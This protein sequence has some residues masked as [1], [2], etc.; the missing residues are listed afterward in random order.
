MPDS[1][2]SAI[3]GAIGIDSS[4]SAAGVDSG[5]IVADI[6]PG[7]GLTAAE[8][9]RGVT[10]RR[11]PAAFAT[12]RFAAFASVFVVAAVPTVAA[13]PATG[14]LATGF[15]ETGF[16]A[17]TL[18]GRTDLAADLATG[19]A[20]VFAAF[21]P[22]V[23]TAVALVTAAFLTGAVRCLATVTVLAAVFA[24]TLEAAAAFEADADLAAPAFAAAAFDTDPAFDAAAPV[25]D[26]APAFDTDPAFDAAAPAVD[27]APAFDADPAFAAAPAFR[28]AEDVAPPRSGVLGLGTAGRVVV[29]VRTVAAPVFR[30]AA[31]A[32]FLTAGFDFP[33]PVVALV[34]AFLAAAIRV[35]LLANDCGLVSAWRLRIPAWTQGVG[36]GVS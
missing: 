27:A 8:V 6:T 30:A 2:G 3:A 13:L 25:F 32:T 36:A 33:A 29:V 1:V 4:M 35:F 34:G 18:A 21:T 22:I 9:R 17:V 28:A 14:F 15:F 7:I 26:T 5:G 20:T 23:F 16:G 31:A 24:A 11:L 19:F 10:G 12:P